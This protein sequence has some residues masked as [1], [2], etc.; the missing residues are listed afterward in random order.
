MSTNARPGA[1]GH[2]WGGSDPQ[3]LP[4][5][6]WGL[7]VALSPRICP[8]LALSCFQLYRKMRRGG[9]RRGAEASQHRGERP[10]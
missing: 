1:R 2:A 10:R 3:H 5:E 6:T 4:R 9:R 7:F 8:L